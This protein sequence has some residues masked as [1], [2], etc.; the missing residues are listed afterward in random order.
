MA[1]GINQ[2]GVILTGPSSTNLG[3]HPLRVLDIRFD[4]S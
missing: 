4:K 3:S 2:F 1:N